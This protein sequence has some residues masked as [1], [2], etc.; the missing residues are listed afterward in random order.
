MPQ[1]AIRIHSCKRDTNLSMS[2]SK[3]EAYT[4]EKLAKL[5]QQASQSEC[6]PTVF[7]EPLKTF[8]PTDSDDNAEAVGT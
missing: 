6:E 8:R 3:A 2:L 5:S 1:Y 7:I 4:I